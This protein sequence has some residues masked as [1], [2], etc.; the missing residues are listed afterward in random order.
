VCQNVIQC[1][2]TEKRTFLRQRVE[3]KLASV[4]FAQRNY[5]AAIALIDTLLVELKS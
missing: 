2:R 3:A 4:M 5:G 1:C